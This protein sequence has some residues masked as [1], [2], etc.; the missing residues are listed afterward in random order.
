VGLASQEGYVTWRIL[1]IANLTIVAL[2]S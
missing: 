2:I 1:A